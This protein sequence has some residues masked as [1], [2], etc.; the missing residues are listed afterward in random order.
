[1]LS[2]TPTLPSPRGPQLIGHY[3]TERGEIGLG[4]PRALPE[5]I[6][7]TIKFQHRFLIDFWSQNDPKIDPEAIKNDPKTGPGSNVV[8]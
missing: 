5:G 6:R 8:F 2:S 7:K 1:M 4:R 3:P